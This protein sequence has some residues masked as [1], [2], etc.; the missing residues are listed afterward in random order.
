MLAQ[1]VGGE[2]FGEGGEGVDGDGVLLAE[3]GGEGGGDDLVV[4]HGLGDGP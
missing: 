4:A 3:E 2:F 1:A